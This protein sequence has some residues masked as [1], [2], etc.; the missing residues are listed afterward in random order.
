MIE[1]QI[2]N[3]AINYIFTHA[4]EELSVENVADYCGYSKFYLER[5]FKAETG[6]SI[7]S[8]IKRCKIELSAFRL[9]VEKDRSITEIGGDYG[10]SASN[11]AVLFKIILKKLRRSSE[12]TLLKLHFTIRFFILKITRLK[13]MK[14]AQR[15]S[16]L[17]R[18]L[19]ILY[20]TNGARVIITS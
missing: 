1:N 9:K 8:F 20:F 7:Y 11:Y 3:S 2:I 17:K 14:N 18:Y 6:E 12:K 16:E 19:T 13:L 5:L 10:Y 15:K 4:D